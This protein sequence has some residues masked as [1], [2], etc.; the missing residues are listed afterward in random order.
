MRLSIGI[1]DTVQCREQ[2]APG[3]RFTY[4]RKCDVNGSRSPSRTTTGGSDEHETMIE[5]RDLIQLQ[6][7]LDPQLIADEI[8]FFR[9]LFDFLAETRHRGSI[10]GGV[11]KHIVQQTIEQNEIVGHES[12]NETVHDRL[13]DNLDTSIAVCVR[14]CARTLYFLFIFVLFVVLDSLAFDIAGHHQ[15][16]LQ[17]A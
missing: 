4:N 1:L 6:D 13:N 9:R 5:V 14:V 11:G 12:R 17:R 2:H 7:F 10:V 8:E 15:H 16:A 3:H